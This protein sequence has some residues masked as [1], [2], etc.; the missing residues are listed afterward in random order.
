LA[1]AHL[2]AGHP[3]IEGLFGRESIS[4]REEMVRETLASALA[5]VD[6][7]P[8]LLGNLEAM[9]ASHEEYGV[10]SEMYERWAESMLVALAHVLTD[11]DAAAERV[12]R[13]VLLAICA[14]MRE[15]GKRG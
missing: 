7:E 13:C 4:E 5:H 2:F 14:P 15:A 3:E 9:G 6:A 1:F 8:W 11:W 12:W 10:R